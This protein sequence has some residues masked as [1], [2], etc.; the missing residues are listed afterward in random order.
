MHKHRLLPLPALLLVAMSMTFNG[1]LDGPKGIFSDC[2]QLVIVV[3]P[4]DTSVHAQLWRYEKTGATWKAVAV[5]HP[6]N[7]GKKGLAWGKG[8]QSVKPGL[9]K[10]EGDQRS[11]AGIFRFGPAFGYAPAEEISL[12]LPY[13]RVTENQLCVE[14]SDSR[15]YN[16]IVDETRVKKDWKSREYM[17][18]KDEQYKWGIFVNQNLPP[19]D[20]GGS[21]I[22]FHLWR[23]PG[24]GTLGCT[25]MTEENLLALLQWL[26]PAKKPLLM[27]M[28]AAQYADYQPKFSLPA[29]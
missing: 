12:K 1:P 7:L 5:P 29:L 6:V 16:Q 10:K 3:A 26:D 25:A 17:L 23:A 22:F 8:L 21:C 9:Q 11:P 24:S 19:K 13:I 18:R 20:E 14:D 15:F 28:T 27:Q 4:A 2:R